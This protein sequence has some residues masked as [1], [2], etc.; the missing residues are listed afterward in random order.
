MTAPAPGRRVHVSQA[1][2]VVNQLDTRYVTDAARADDDAELED[3]TS[4]HE[5]VPCAGDDE[6]CAISIRSDDDW[7]SASAVFGLAELADDPRFATG[8]A[9]LAHRS[10]L[11]AQVSTWTRDRTPQEVAE[12]LQS[13]GVP[14]GQMNRPPDILEDPQLCERKL[15]SDMRHPLFDHPLAAETGPAPFRHIPPAPQRPAPLPGQDTREICH[16]V[17]GMSSEETDQLIHDGVLFAST[18]TAEGLA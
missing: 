3:D 5:V 7:R 17:L 1:E 12:A 14:A 9:R 6:W 18:D 8:E 4:L 13:A 2:A 16:K 10:E 15:F 11:V